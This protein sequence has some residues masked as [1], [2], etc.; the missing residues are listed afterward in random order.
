MHIDACKQGYI[1]LHVR[2]WYI[3]QIPIIL[4][5]VDE[6]NKVKKMKGYQ[7]EGMAV[8]L[9]GFVSSRTLLSHG[10]LFNSFNIQIHLHTLL[11][12]FYSSLILFI[13]ETKLIKINIKF[14]LNI[15]LTI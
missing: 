15:K 7:K 3:F 14:I 8:G 4:I 11:W 9:F 5:G 6:N 13:N 12:V 1:I 10:P 2:E